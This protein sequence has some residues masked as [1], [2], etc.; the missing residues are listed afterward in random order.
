MDQ[1]VKEAICQVVK[2]EPFAQ[3][4]KLELVFLEYGH[5]VIEMTYDPAVAN[6]IYDR[7]HGGAIYSLIDEAFQA[8][9]QT[10]GTI[11]VAL[12]VNV[13]YITSPKPHTRLRAEARRV[14]QTKRTAGYHIIVTD[15]EEQVIATC[16]ALAYQTGK[17]IPFL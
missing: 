14:S 6:N 7:A 12:N 11:A 2:K 4:L 10:D 5:S 9:G 13:T 8:A 3:V 16:Q 17:P 1:R 15:P